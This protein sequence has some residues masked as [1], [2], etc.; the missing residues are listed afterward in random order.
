MKCSLPFGLAGLASWLLVAP[1]APAHDLWLLPPEAPTPG[2]PGLLRANSGEAFPDSEH[3]PDP[4]AFARRVLL[5]PDGKEG[6]LQ[7]AGQEGK[8]GLLR[9]EP[10]APGVYILAVETK[11]KLITLDAAAFN[12]YLVGDGLT[13]VY[14][15]RAREKS[16]DQPGTERYSKS[17]KALVRVGEGGGGDPCRVVGLPLEIVPLHDPFALKPGARCG[18]GCCSGASRCRTRTSA[19][20]FR[21]TATTP[22]APCAA[23]PGARPSFP[24]LAPA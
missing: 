13:P 5:R 24:S 20:N 7:A 15:L 14:R 4:A 19:G 12:A 3:A 23:M 2:Q 10:A 18:C 1:P 11:P 6:D 21:A 8:S 17:P 22:G 16:L 9:F